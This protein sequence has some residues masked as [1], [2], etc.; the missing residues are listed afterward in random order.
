MKSPGSK[1]N[2][3][4]NNWKGLFIWILIALLLRWQAVEPRWIPS[5]S[6]IPTLQIQDRILIEKITP[7]L[8]KKLN[9]HLNLNTIVIFK[10]PKILT[11]TGYSDGSAL[12][13]RIVGLPGD[14]IEVSNGKLYRNEKEINEPWIQEP[15]QY[16]MEAIKVPD[17][18]IWV[19]GDNRNNSLDS[20]I[21]GPLPE[22]NLIGTALARYWPLKEIGL[23]G[24]HNQK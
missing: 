23:F 10:P 20:H 8:N 15:I 18:S 3:T 9:K 19:L 12:I 13:K 6:M 17:Y 16:E 2:Q 22:K 7:R 24:S 4:Q 5:G 21:W 11:E 1:E 14:K